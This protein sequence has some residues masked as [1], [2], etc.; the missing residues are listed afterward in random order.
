M[1]QNYLYHCV[2]PENVPNGDVWEE[3]A[4]CDFALNFPQRKMVAV[5]TL[6]L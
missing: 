4:M 5:L 2:Q 6:N 3:F 1:S